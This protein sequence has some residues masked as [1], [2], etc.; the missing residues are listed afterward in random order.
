[1]AD[2][3][4][5][6]KPKGIQGKSF[7]ELLDNPSKKIDPYAFSQYEKSGHWGHTVT[8]G[9]YRLVQWQDGSKTVFEL[10]DH[11]SDPEENK[12]IAAQESSRKIV[13][14]LS[15]KINQHIEEDKL[16]KSNIGHTGLYAQH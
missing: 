15:V 16:L 14:R 11:L 2:I 5:L 8:D 13:Q 7:K 1:L 9:R 4:G 3:A 12:N 10:Y 6:P